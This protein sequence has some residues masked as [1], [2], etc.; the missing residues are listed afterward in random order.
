MR[1]WIQKMAIVFI[2]IMISSSVFS[3]D[4]KIYFLADTINVSKENQL[5]E[6]GTE[7]PFKYFTFFCSCIPSDK[8]N[9]GFKYSLRSEDKILTK[10]PDFNYVSWEYLSS[11]FSKAG[12]NFDRQYDLIIVEVLPGKKYRVNP[13]EHIFVAPTTY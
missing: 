2:L 11:V 6:I 9:I 7:G 8:G 13:V 5:L 1:N 3:Q 10:K 12:K 4:K